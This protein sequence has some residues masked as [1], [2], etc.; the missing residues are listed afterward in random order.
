MPDRRPTP[1]FFKANVKPP[2]PLTPSEIRKLLWEG[3][4]GIGVLEGKV[5]DK[6]GM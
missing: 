6:K 5:S 4:G 2:W 3:L 1:L